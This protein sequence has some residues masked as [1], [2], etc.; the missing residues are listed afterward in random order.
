M[1]Y[2]KKRELLESKNL[3]K[4]IVETNG[5]NNLSKHHHLSF[6]VTLNFRGAMWVYLEKHPNAKYF[7]INHQF[8]NF[9]WII[10]I[11]TWYH[12]YNEYLCPFRC[13]HKSAF[14]TRP[15]YAS[16]IEGSRSYYSLFSAAGSK[17]GIWRGT[18]FVRS[19]PFS[20]LQKI[21]FLS[22]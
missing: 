2:T 3:T 14:F 1:V 9:Y 12:Y 22:L 7:F 20:F 5:W 17:G 15:K 8:L 16:L 6:R 21:F 10:I 4:D 19:N 11:L 13:V 18:F